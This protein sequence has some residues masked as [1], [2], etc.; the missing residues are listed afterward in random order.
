MLHTSSLRRVAGVGTALALSLTSFVPS[1]L[2]ASAP[3]LKGANPFAILASGSVSNSNGAESDASVVLGNVGG[4]SVSNYAVF[5]LNTPP[6]ASDAIVNG[7]IVSGSNAMY[8]TA[9]TDAGAAYDALVSQGCDTTVS[10]TAPALNTITPGVT[11]F[12]GDAN[13]AGT[14]MLDIQNN[15]NAI[16]VIKVAGKLNVAA[17]A[18]VQFKSGEASASTGCSTNW[19]VG[20]GATL[21]SGS[22]FTAGNILVGS[23]DIVL[24]N[25]AELIGG[26]LFAK[27]GSVSLTSSSVGINRDQSGV[28]TCDPNGK[29]G[30]A[31][32]SATGSSTSSS[33]G[34]GSTSSG[35]SAS[36]STTVPVV[37]PT[38]PAA[39]TTSTPTSTPTSTTTTTPKT[40]PKTGAGPS[41]M[42]VTLVLTA[43]FACIHFIRRAL[44]SR[45]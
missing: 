28:P 29:A 41:P 30:T 7:S 5:S 27:N 6:A 23:G 45:S 9:K 42:A 43:A 25:K 36:A 40:L 4:S 34:S 11:C 44:V 10:G 12:T 24:Q 35:S 3:G 37:T 15:T 38:T 13:L 21:G 1:S 17:N 32:G 14:T 20:A 16:F 33:S 31:S 8:A 22:S 2:A 19:Q 39:P 18:K 26:M